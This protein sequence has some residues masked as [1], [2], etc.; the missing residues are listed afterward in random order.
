MKHSFEYMAIKRSEPHECHTRSSCFQH[1]QCRTVWCTCSPI[2]IDLA[3]AKYARFVMYFRILT[4]NSGNASTFTLHIV[5]ICMMSKIIHWT[6][7]STWDHRGEQSWR[8][9]PTKKWL[10]YFVCFRRWSSRCNYL[11]QLIKRRALIRIGCYVCVCQMLWT[12]IKEWSH[13]SSNDLFL[14][15]E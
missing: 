7:P 6:P 12:D 11:N 8:R 3:L 14:R 15:H 5:R 10:A 2:A 13:I 4:D 1:T 9:N